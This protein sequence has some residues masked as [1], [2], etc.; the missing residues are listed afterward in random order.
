MRIRHLSPQA[1]T[2]FLASGLFMIGLSTTASL[3]A[4]EKAVREHPGAHALPKATLAADVTPAN[5]R[6]RKCPSPG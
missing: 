4:P 2:R 1:R 5:Q 6:T 3:L